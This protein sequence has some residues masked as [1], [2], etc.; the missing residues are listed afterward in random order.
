MGVGNDSIS[1]LFCD[2]VLVGLLLSQMGV[3]NDLISVFLCSFG[4]LMC[5]FFS[6]VCSVPYGHFNCFKRVH[7]L[8]IVLTMFCSDAHHR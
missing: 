8:D 1:A 5:P 3:R 6:I 2:A 7:Y 4:M